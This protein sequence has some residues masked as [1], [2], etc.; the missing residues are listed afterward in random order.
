MAKAILVLISCFIA[1]PALAAKAK[2]ATDF[3]G[4]KID[5]AFNDSI[6][7]LLDKGHRVFSGRSFISKSGIEE[8]DAS[9]PDKV[10]AVLGEEAKSGRLCISISTEEVKGLKLVTFNCGNTT[11]SKSK[12]VIRAYQLSHM[13][14]KDTTAPSLY[15]M[16]FIFNLDGQKEVGSGLIGKY[17]S[18]YTFTPN[19]PCT[20]DIVTAMKLEPKDQNTCFSSV[21]YDGKTFAFAQGHGASLENGKL[22]DLTVWDNAKQKQADTIKSAKHESATKSLGF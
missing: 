5:Q 15:S 3:S 6:K 8:V 21:W 18:D 14:G 22:F 17:G 9:T 4:V 1:A 11:S 2:I 10:R 20:K 19:K 16:R 7:F 13:I 12:D